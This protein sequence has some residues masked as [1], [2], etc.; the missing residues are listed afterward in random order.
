[1]NYSD[2][3]HAENKS[4]LNVSSAVVGDSNQLLLIV[5]GYQFQKMDLLSNRM[6]DFSEDH[7][8]SDTAGRPLYADAENNLWVL[9]KYANYYYDHNSKKWMAANY[10][11][12]RDDRANQFWASNTS[13]L[14]LFD[15]RT[16]K[17][18]TSAC[19][20]L[21]VPLLD[22]VKGRDIRYILLDSRRRLWVNTWNENLYRYDLATQKIRTYRNV[23]KVTDEHKK[24]RNLAFSV[25]SIYEDDHQQLWL[26]TYHAGLL[27]YDEAGNRFTRIATN[28]PG[29][30]SI[31]YNYEIA[32]IFQD[33]DGNIWLGTD[34]GIT[35]FNP[36]HQYFRIIRHES[37]GEKTLPKKEIVNFIEARQGDILVGTWG[38]GITVFDSLWRFKKKLVFPGAFEKNMVWSFA[39]D[40]DGK[41]WAGC[42]H[43][44][45]HIYDPA[46]GRVHTIQPAALQHSTIRSMQKDRQGN[47]LFG[48]HNG[49]VAV[50]MKK[51]NSFFSY[52][53][54]IPARDDLAPIRYLFIDSAGLCWV[55]TEN[56]LK[57]FDPEKRIFTGIYRQ[58]K[59]SPNSFLGLED[60]NDSI[61]VA[62]LVNGGLSYFNKIKKTFSFPGA[63][64]K[65]RSSTVHAVRKDPY[66]NIW[67]TTDYDLYKLNTRENRYAG[68]NMEPGLINSDFSSP[69]YVLRN[70]RWAV[71]TSTEIICFY[72]GILNGRSAVRLEAE[73]T[74]LEIDNKP[75]FIDSFLN[76][77]EPVPLTYQQNV[78]TIEFATLHYSNISQIKYDYR[79]SGIN[80]DWVSADASSSASYA[81]LAPGKYTFSVVAEDEGRRGPVASFRFIIRP[82]FWLS[83]WFRIG[84]LLLIACL[85]YWL[86]R[87]RIS[88][89]RREA[90]LKQ[91]IAETEMMALRAQMNPHFIFN[92]INS[93]DALIQ[94]NDKYHATLYLNKFAKLIRNILDSSKQNTIS[95]SKDI[96]TLRLYID[97]EQFRSE[98]QFSAEILAD[99]SLLKEDYRVP[100]MI[101][102]PYVENAILHGLRYKKDRDGQLIIAI[103]KEEDYLVY[104]V[105]DNGV[106]RKPG[107]EDHKRKSYGIQMSNERVRLFNR[108]NK[109][110]VEITDLHCNGQPA[111]T[112]VRVFLKIQ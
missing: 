72:P 82:P 68:Y 2:E 75:V 60:L 93:I 47:I 43:G 31:Q 61:L 11:A 97:L 41:I 87:R 51:Q 100:P 22:R 101:I 91:Q 33:R 30:E 79:L 71:S 80:K 99:Q 96:E 29:S 6:T 53:D 55:S 81:N 13:G 54:S 45:I 94:S 35:L 14:M 66:G 19:N 3:L 63:L 111:G 12:V 21:H 39:E 67:F 8:L 32:A 9:G 17:C 42:Q 18:Y 78:L 74:G 88:M 4:L 86:I 52:N 106:G 10:M 23:I 105:E 112:R 50:W 25:S 69:F 89:I 36:Y 83:W 107:P 15:D 37:A 1:V 16:K 109:A 44:Y 20:P 38:G 7:I 65:I 73:I 27:K 46:T 58:A 59:Y 76:K 103:R 95:F 64:D 57:L 26:G 77:K 104:T 62:G 110:S 108:E 85:F 90:A 24:T 48:L 40:D 56:G 84:S 5:S 28:D 49:K 70:G 102:Q 34:K 92:C 98:Y